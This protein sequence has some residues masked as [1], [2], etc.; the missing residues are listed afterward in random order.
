MRPLG[1]LHSGPIGLNGYGHFPEAHFS[2]L[3]MEEDKWGEGG[4]DS[5]PR[6]PFSPATPPHHERRVK[7]RR[8]KCLE[9]NFP[10]KGRQNV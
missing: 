7:S 4:L 8:G 1:E 2:N 6:R 10:G 3:S 5:S 9:I